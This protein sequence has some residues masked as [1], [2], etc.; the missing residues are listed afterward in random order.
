M[1]HKV[2]TI[3]LDFIILHINFLESNYD[4]IKRISTS[5]GI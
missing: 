4:K 1:K 5:R 3:T 2:Q